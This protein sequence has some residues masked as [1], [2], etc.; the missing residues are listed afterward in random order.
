MQP[1]EGR[2]RPWPTSGLADE[3][4]AAVGRLGASP[5]A[6]SRASRPEARHEVSAQAWTCCQACGA[7]QAAEHRFCAECG[8]RLQRQPVQENG[9]EPTHGRGVAS[10]EGQETGA[11][12]SSRGREAEQVKASPAASEEQARGRKLEGAGR[13]AAEP[14]G[15]LGCRLEPAP[16]PVEEPRPG[17]REAEE[18]QGPAGYQERP[19]PSRARELRLEG[20]GDPEEPPASP[21]C[22]QEEPAP[23]RVRDP[24]PDGRD[25]EELQG[26]PAARRVE[27]APRRARDRRP[28]GAGASEAAS[29]AEAAKSASRQP[30]KELV[31]M[32]EEPGFLAA[33]ARKGGSEAKS[34][35]MSAR[36]RHGT[37]VPTGARA[38]V[39]VPSRQD[40]DAPGNAGG[41]VPDAVVA[42]YPRDRLAPAAKQPMG[43]SGRPLPVVPG[44][45]GGTRATLLGSSGKPLPAVPGWQASRQSRRQRA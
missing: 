34:G 35:C 40:L 16:H 28:A 8:A 6:A 21:V 25:A 23:R 17:G 15:S 32:W 42:G 37:P 13:G 31:P 10:F 20:A 29:H 7:R 4:A 36:Q 41:T 45:D 24:K 27:P 1:R 14:R 12:A 30:L 9:A 22:P 3:I 18:R 38:R 44:W 11:P 5:A 33:T 39:V 19:A 26:P 2:G 43:S